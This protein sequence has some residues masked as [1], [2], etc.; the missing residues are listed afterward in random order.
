VQLDEAGLPILLADALDRHGALGAV[1]VW[2]MVRR[3]ASY[4]VC[5]GPV[6]PEDRWE[7]HAGYSPFTLA[8]EVAA[9]LVAATFAERRGHARSAQYLRE[10]ADYWNSHIEHWTY[11]SG[12]KLAERLEIGGYYV[13]LA[14]PRKKRR[15]RASAGARA[16]AL[17]NH[18]VE[19]GP[20][21]YEAIVSPD[22]LAL[23]RFGLRRADDPRIV[24][25]VRA[26]DDVLCSQTPTGPVWHRFTG[27]HYGEHKD[28][29]PFD[30]DGIG[31]GWPL[32]AGE[33]AHYEVA[34][35]DMTMARKLR[36]TM[37]AQA[38]AGGL[39]PE[40]VWDAAD[41]P[42]HGLYKGR[43][44]GSA[45]PLVWAHAEFLKL[46]RS[47]EEER[48]FDTP[49]VVRERYAHD[50]T[51]SKIMIWRAGSGQ[52]R[53]APGLIL[54]VERRRPFAITWSVAGADR[55][56]SSD[57]I[58]SGVGIHYAD[59]PTDELPTGAEVRFAMRSIVRDGVW[60]REH[61]VRVSSHTESAS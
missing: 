18:P 32:L 60:S 51:E 24:D 58:D 35:G 44:T 26:I 45:M 55:R 30:G 5:N 21:P 46:C 52:H 13:R 7:E 27:D 22:A 29:S 8:V 40:Q 42:A 43:P 2:P 9:L 31:R 4:I 1:D 28:G 20:A 61:V 57:S 14:P 39:I 50:G 16:T 49:P 47:I 54:R 48:V 10:T 37:I 12:T 6:T 23:V 38:S 19:N 17:K 53:L 15:E 11:V 34:R 36:R 3:A 25:T 33:R 59:L 56:G 41:I